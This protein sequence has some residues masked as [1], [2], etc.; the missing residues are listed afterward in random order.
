MQLRNDKTTRCR[1]FLFITVRQSV[2]AEKA[3]S[4]SQNDFSGKSAIVCEKEIKKKDF[5]KIEEQRE[6]FFAR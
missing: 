3:F 6:E 2:E 1:K 4:S 5:L